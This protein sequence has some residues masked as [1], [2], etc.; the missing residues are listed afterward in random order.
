MLIILS[1]LGVVRRINLVK[2]CRFG[3]RDGMLCCSII[4]AW[5]DE[6]LAIPGGV[7]LDIKQEKRI[8]QC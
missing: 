4:V 8:G 3:V 1:M 5:T 2:E 6:D 7:K